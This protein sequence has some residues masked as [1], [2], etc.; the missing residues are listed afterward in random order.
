[1]LLATEEGSKYLCC[2][3]CPILEQLASNQRVM[4][5]NQNRIIELYWKKIQDWPT[6]IHVL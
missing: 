4:M 2:H 5:E 3:H 6:F 1:V